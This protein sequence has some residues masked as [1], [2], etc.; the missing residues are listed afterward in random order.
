[1]NQEKIQENKNISEPLLTKPCSS[2]DD[3]SES[4]ELLISLRLNGIRECS[5]CRKNGC[6]VKSELMS[7]ALKAM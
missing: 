5:A 4:K 1:M 3:D 7:M 6:P 2:F